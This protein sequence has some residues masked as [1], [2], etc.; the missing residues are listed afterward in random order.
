MNRLSSRWNRFRALKLIAVL[1]AA[2]SIVASAWA[3][4]P[5]YVEGQILVKPKAGVTAEKVKE[6]HKKHGGSPGWR[7]P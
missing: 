5:R 1:C 7:P 6:S 2:V 4:K 3:E